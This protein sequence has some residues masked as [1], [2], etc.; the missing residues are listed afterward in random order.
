[1]FDQIEI[2]SKMA[3]SISKLYESLYQTA[4]DK[5][6]SLTRYI[7]KFSDKYNKYKETYNFPTKYKGM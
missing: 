2:D 4:F 5:N 3:R 6:P 1:M 7:S